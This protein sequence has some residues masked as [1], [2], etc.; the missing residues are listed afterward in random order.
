MSNGTGRRTLADVLRSHARSRPDGVALVEGE[1]TFTWRAANERASRVAHALR[2]E[3]VGHGDR[4]LW[5]GQ[6]SFR[7]QELL[8]ACCKLGALFCPANWR[9]QP[10]ELA[11]VIDDLEPR[12]VV[13]QHEEVD[14]TVHAGRAAATHT[15]SLW[16]AHDDGEYEAWVG[17]VLARHR[18]SR[19]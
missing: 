15:N 2:G 1:T 5:L 14:A 8:L 3:G 13:W 7:L 17:R 4:V 11:F 9:Q 12:V 16:I 6:N 18:R 10:E 19:C